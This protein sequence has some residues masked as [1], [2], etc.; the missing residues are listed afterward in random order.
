MKK[1]I[2][3]TIP[4]K[5]LKKLINDE[6]KACLTESLREMTA[7]LAEDPEVLNIDQVAALLNYSKSYLYKLTSGRQIPYYKK[8]GKTMHFLRSEI[9]E[10]IK[11]GR[12]KTNEEI[13]IEAATYVT[14]KKWKR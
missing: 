3:I 14:L 7:K 11:T 9:I 10:W 2:T 1:D 4:V 13:E 6:V 8:G 5:L 12:I